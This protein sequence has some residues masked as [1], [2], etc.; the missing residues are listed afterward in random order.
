MQY[1]ALNCFS[2]SSAHEFYTLLNF[3]T[4]FFHSRLP[5]SLPSLWRLPSSL[6][7]GSSKSGPY[8]EIER[9]GEGE[10][11]G[12]SVAAGEEAD[13]GGS[14]TA[15]ATP[16]MGFFPAFFRSPNRGDPIFG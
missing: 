15:P 2:N 6:P 4:I 8:R 1:Q 16:K 9:S 14:R 3:L 13:V 10:V 7:G 11:S 5:S 12:G